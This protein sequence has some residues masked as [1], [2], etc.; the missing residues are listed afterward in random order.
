MLVDV[1]N[2]YWNPWHA[3]VK[4]LHIKNLAPSGNNEF[5]SSA[6]RELG[7]EMDFY[8][9][10]LARDDDQMQTHKFRSGLR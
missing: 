1:L 7:E 9:V 6:F 5:I 4:Q 10:T 3:E 8:Y 2:G